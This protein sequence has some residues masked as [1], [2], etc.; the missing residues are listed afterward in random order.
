M[1][2]ARTTSGVVVGSGGGVERRP[3]E[4]NQREEDHQHARF[5]RTRTLALDP[6]RLVGLELRLV[7]GALAVEPGR[8]PGS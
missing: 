4:R 1:L 5:F 3:Q 2:F 6:G 8:G 7:M